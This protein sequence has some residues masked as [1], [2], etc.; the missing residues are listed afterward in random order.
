MANLN[1]NALHFLKILKIWW[2]ESNKLN[3][4]NSEDQAQYLKVFCVFIIE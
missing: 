4:L 3:F 2:D 1:N